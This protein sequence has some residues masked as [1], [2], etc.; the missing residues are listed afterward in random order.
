M[1]SDDE[2][3]ALLE[4]RKAAS[5]TAMKMLGNSPEH[6]IRILTIMRLVFP[7][8]TLCPVRD[9][10]GLSWCARLQ[11]T[12]TSQMRQAGI[13]QT[14]RCTTPRRLS[15]VLLR[16]LELFDLLREVG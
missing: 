12:V 11:V 16:Q 6:R 13:A 1:L 7:E 9:S 14:I 8:W 5:F 10:L 2:L 15:E 4:E 3:T